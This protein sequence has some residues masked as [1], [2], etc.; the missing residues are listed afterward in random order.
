VTIQLKGHESANWS[1]SR[2]TSYLRCGK[3]YELDRVM[4]APRLPGWY[5]V[6]GSAVH[7]VTEALDRLAFLMGENVTPEAEVEAMFHA[8]LDELTEQEREK[9]GIDPDKWL[10]GGRGNS[11]HR[12][13]HW[14]AEGPQIVKRW[15]EWREE[16]PWQWA[17]F[18]GEP[19]IELRLEI[20]LGGLPFVAVIDRAAIL[21]NDSL[22]VVDLKTGKKPEGVLQLGTYATAL[23]LAGFERPK[24]GIYWL[25]KTGKHT[26][27]VPLDRYTKDYLDQI[28]GEAAEGV[29]RGV[30]PPS[31]GEIC[32]MCSV[33]RACYTTDGDLSHLYDRL[34]P[35]LRFYGPELPPEGEN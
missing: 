7:E 21:P 24:Y 23:Q 5:L 31:P 4:K 19:G 1:F 18:D 32:R 35:D 15:L 9:S 30:F 12:A 6:G 8:K 29:R 34:D 14:H 3:G 13:D 26:A 16:H 22:A 27:P 28:F 10:A 33:A 20:E 17:M 2:Y 11:K 25:G